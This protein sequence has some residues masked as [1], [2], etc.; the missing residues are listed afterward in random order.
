MVLGFLLVA[1]EPNRFV[2]FWV[3]FPRGAS[4]RCVCACWLLLSPVLCPGQSF[5]FAN[6]WSRPAKNPIRQRHRP[7]V[8]GS[9]QTGAGCLFSVEAHTNVGRRLFG[10][11]RE[12]L[13]QELN[14]VFD[15][16]KGSHCWFRCWL[17]CGWSAEYISVGRISLS[18]AL[19]SIRRR[20]STPRPCDPGH[21]NRHCWHAVIHSAQVLLPL[22]CLGV[23]EVELPT[24]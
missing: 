17:G 16:S 3:S 1:T 2:R 18:P 20:F 22:A 14:F 9:K 13:A 8:L 21:S 11:W 24:Y 6:R 7:P 19:Y 10:R 5:C 15:P 12:Q 23:E 4:L